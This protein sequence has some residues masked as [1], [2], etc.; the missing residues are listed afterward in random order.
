MEE[1]IWKPIEGYENYEVSNTG[2]VRSLRVNKSGEVVSRILR[3]HD[4]GH[5]Y[6]AAPLIVNKRQRMMY[7][8]RLVAMAFIPNVDNLPQVNHKDENKSNNNVDNLEWCTARYNINYGNLRERVRASLLKSVGVPVN[9][10]DLEGNLVRRYECSKEVEKYGFKRRA[11]IDVCNHR[12]GHKISSKTYKGFVWR[13]D[14]DA[15]TLTV[16]ERSYKIMQ[17]RIDSNIVRVFDGLE[18]AMKNAGIKHP[19]AIKSAIYGKRK[20]K[21]K[22]IEGFFCDIVRYNSNN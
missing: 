17:S 9:Q 2:L 6:L 1:V 5:G 8:H 15:F 4:N 22:P 19:T 21:D 20:D 18:D 11:V 14:G 12:K 13:Y 10:Y 16:N 7:V 3:L